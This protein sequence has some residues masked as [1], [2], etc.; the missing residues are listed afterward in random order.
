[1]NSITK[2]YLTGIVFKNASETIDKHRQSKQHPFDNKPYPGATDEELLDFII[3]I[4]YFDVRLKDFLLGNLAEDTI[5]ISQAWENEFIKKT[6][7]WAE[8]FEWLQGNDHFLSEAVINGM[9]KEK[10]FL[11]LPY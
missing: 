8:S 5:I 11:T 1:M 3:S 7:L 4:P 10:A 9:Q 2:D 6:K